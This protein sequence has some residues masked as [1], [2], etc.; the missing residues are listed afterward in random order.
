MPPPAFFRAKRHVPSRRQRHAVGDE[1]KKM[2]ESVI[3]CLLNNKRVSWAAVP[4]GDG[5]FLR[6]KDEGAIIVQTP[7]R[8][9][10]DIGE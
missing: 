9:P 7:L 6:G 4:A 1:S 2:P 5:R 3:A 10:R 8:S